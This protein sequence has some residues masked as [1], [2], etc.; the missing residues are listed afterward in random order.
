MWK[1]ILEAK[2]MATPTISKVT[3]KL[4]SFE[5]KAW[6]TTFKV[7]SAPIR[8]VAG[9]VTSPLMAAGASLSAG[10]MV[11]SS[12][13]TYAGFESTMSQVKA[14]SG[15]TEAQFE[16]LTAKAKE[17]GATTKFTAQEAGEAF[18]YMAMAGWRPRQMLGG[19]SGI[20]N[21][22]AASG[23]DLGTTSDIV[24]DAL[25]AFGLKASDAGHFS[26]VLAQ[27]SSNANTTVGTMGESFKYVAPVAGAMR[28]KIEDTSLALGL[29]ANA[30]IKGS[31]AG[32]SLKTALSNMASPTKAMATAM[33]KYG[34]SLTDS[35]GGMKS[36]TGVMQ[37]LR[38]SLGGLSETEQTAAAS[39]IFGKEAMAG[40]LAIINASADDWDKLSEAVN[41]ADGASQR[42]A[43]TM[44]DNLSGKFTLFQ[45]ALDGVKISLGERVS[46]Y[47][48]TVLDW[49]TAKMPDVESALM[50]GMDTIDN[51]IDGAKD[52]ISSFTSTSEWEN[53]DIFGKMHIAWDSLI[54]DPLADWWSGIESSIKGK[55]AQIGETIGE[56]LSGGLL[57]LLGFDVGEGVNEGVS[58][59]ASFAKGFSKG[60]ESLPVLGAAFGAVG[61]QFLNA[62]RLLT[63]D[64]DASS[65]ASAAAIMRTGIPLLKGAG[66]AVSGVKKAFGTTT[67]TGEDG[68][69]MV[70]PGIGRK[71]LGSAAQGT[72]LLGLGANTAIKLGAG[73]FAGGASLS[74]GAL[75]ALGL[76]SIAGGVVGGLGLVSAGINGVKAF[77]AEDPE[78]A[79]AHRDAA[80]LEGGGAL[81]GAA[82]GAAIGSVVPVLG[83][84]A[85]ALI[86][87]GI[88]GLGGIIGGHHVNKNYE[89]KKA[90]EE[91]IAAKSKYALEGA[92]FETESL[93]EA[94]KDASVSAD[95][96]GMMMQEAVSQKIQDGFGS[97]K[98]SAREIQD[99]VSQIMFPD[100]LDKKLDK[101]SDAAEQA[102][103]SLASVGSDVSS[104]EKWNWRA[105][106]G[107]Q[108]SDEDK[109]S[110]MSSIDALTADAMQY[111]EDKHYE[112]KMALDLLIEPGTPVDM[113]S[114]IDSTYTEIGDRVRS[115]SDEAERVAELAL[116]DGVISPDASIKF[117]M[118]GVEMEM[119]EADAMA[120]LQNAVT[121][122]VDRVAKAGSEAGFQT[123]LA[124]Y[125]G[126]DLT[127]DSFSQL[128][129]GMGEQAA[130]AIDTAADAYDTG[131]SNLN[132][133]YGDDKGNPQYIAQKKEWDS[134]FNTRKAEA[135]APMEAFGLETV[136]N[137]FGSELDGILPKIQGT[138]SEKLGHA[139]HDAWADGVDTDQWGLGEGLSSA[140][141]NLGLKGLDAETQGAVASMMGMISQ[142]LPEEYKS[143]FRGQETADE[144]DGIYEEAMQS[145]GRDGE[146][147]K[148][149]ES[150]IEQADDTGFSDGTAEGIQEAAQ[151]AAENADYSA[152]G[153]SILDGVGSSVDGARPIGSM[154][155]LQEGISSMVESG[156]EGMDMAPA[157]ETFMASFGEALGGVDFS[158]AKGGG[159]GLM[160]GLQDTLA[161]SMENLDLSEV[162][163]SLN[164]RLG[165][166]MSGIDMSEGGDGAGAGLMEGIQA[167]MMA[168][169][170]NVD[171]SEAA[172]SLNGKLGEAM[173]GLEMEETGG[174][175]SEGIQSSISASL[176]SIDLSGVAE[177][178]SVSLN[179]AL[180]GAEAMDFS[181]FGES[182][183]ASLSASVSGMDYSGITSAVGT[184]ISSA[185]EASMGTIQGAI[186]SLYSQVGAAINSAFAAGFQTTTTVT[187]TVNYQLANPTATI[188]FS[189]GG[190][191]TATVSASIASN[192]EGSIVNGRILSW[193]GEDGPEAII[194][195]GAKRRQRGLELW[196]EAGRRLGV[197]EYAEGGIVGAGS[198]GGYMSG[199]QDMEHIFDQSAGA[200]GMGA[201]YNGYPAA[202]DAGSPYPDQD[203]GFPENGT[204][205]PVDTGQGGQGSIAP[206][207][208]I[209]V[210]LSPVFEI[211][212]GSADILEAI[213]GRLR[214]LADDVAVEMAERILEI[215]ENT[216][217]V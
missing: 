185:I 116:A 76:G 4:K 38:D 133:T 182:L 119:S 52:K 51:F 171:L 107:K 155:G 16:K 160:D 48:V 84:A 62:G 121:E 39:T 129:S 175:L 137:S 170:E 13:K 25:T 69:T 106:L 146:R 67:V 75:S 189:G 19:I 41:N 101:F 23:E 148:L 110:Y 134:G 132:L 202:S 164:D 35:E 92:R 11:G 36:L 9:A 167:T 124:R 14:V 27:A 18:N 37:N 95:E 64:G 30:S 45:S 81:T 33:E 208:E 29:M 197:Y 79:A 188:S 209:N 128:L 96:F 82:M 83:T 154:D 100:G 50:R 145:A 181:G 24:T 123:M 108:F 199:P 144:A 143:L 165:E 34:I 201:I 87:L 125:S 166:A 26:D 200:G 10:A 117:T 152:A 142:S 173:S 86:G 31:M 103:S 184:G 32:T 15:A 195:L 118:D 169:M 90:V 105:S 186:S 98:L 66:N 168:S 40:M 42:M 17:M 65:W 6:K 104:L 149:S 190:T 80:F 3:S 44:L 55:A 5:K 176:E 161:S 159:A 141:E 131:M 114:G 150:A 49:M 68:G 196:Q 113:K 93:S 61:G 147:R 120:K 47:L 70:V 217:A 1:T 163:V 153:K 139:L 109:Q 211:Q 192:A 174:G 99:A 210:E 58:I 112:A 177:S 72:G 57:S 212:D 21:L 20:M 46:P 8:K 12:V 213:S 126:A 207:I 127:Y 115:Y 203:T 215:Y 22:A 198:S 73:N 74:A 78:E 204:S 136:A 111:L 206:N 88:G 94:F 56:G 54:G 183:S 140:V 122:Q 63:G 71:I 2:D 172:T 179:E 53:A 97:I 28:Y 151:D 216:P 214:E 158:K 187:I 194:P 205:I 89:E 138:M 43:D 91:T 156:L 191:G 85:G 157:V 130:E 135:V 178:I 77:R 59:G 180:S 7:A 162:A 193:V 60:F 102:G